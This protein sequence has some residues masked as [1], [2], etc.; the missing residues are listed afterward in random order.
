MTDE[1]ETEKE[2]LQL[3]RDIARGDASSSTSLSKSKVT[4]KPV[5]PRFIA[6]YKHPL[7][8][9]NRRHKHEANLRRVL[10][11]V[12]ERQAISAVSLG[13]AWVL[14]E[15][16]IR[17]APVELPDENGFTPL[18]IAC[19]L[20]DYNAVMVLINIEVN[21]NALTVAGYTP[22]FLALS[23][24]AKQCVQLLQEV[25][26]KKHVPLTAVASSSLLFET[27]LKP[28]RNNTQPSVLHLA[29]KN[30]GMP[31]EHHTF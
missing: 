6:L 31:H 14:E 2:Y 20:N 27:D 13:D 24:D 3:L 7:P 16:F 21:I 17:G 22:L 11:C 1:E 5:P 23:S 29:A 12:L 15:V 19:Q 4:A 30:L 28:S 9:S 8:L 18:H 10:C 26:A 25:G